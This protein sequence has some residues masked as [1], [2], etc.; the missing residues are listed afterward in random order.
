ERVASGRAVLVDVREADEIRRERI[1]GAVAAPLSRFDPA[2]AAAAGA[3]KDVVLVCRSGRRA[4]EAAGRLA[5]TGARATVLAG[6]IEGWKKAGLPVETDAKA[7]LP[8]MRQVQI[9]AGSLVFIGIAL[10]AFVSPWFLL[11]PGFVGAGLVV[12]GA[13]GTCGMAT[14]L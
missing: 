1:A 6:G 2:Q 9:T 8:I 11:V 12:A 3:G 14:V 4:A 13:T 7:P 5:G 10:G